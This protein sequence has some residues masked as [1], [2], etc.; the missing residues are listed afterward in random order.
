VRRIGLMKTVAIGDT[1]MLAGIARDVA[2]AFPEATLVLVTGEDNRAAAE[3]FGVA[4]ESLIVRP[5]APLA[6]ARAMRAADLDVLLD[7]GPWARFDAF[8]A[9]AAGARFSVGFRSAGQHRHYAY[10]VAIPH[11]GDRHEIDNFRALAHAIG[12]IADSDPHIKVPDALDRD[13]LPPAPYVVFHPWA[14]GF[15]R[16]LK[17]WPAE[18]WVALG[19]RLASRGWTIALSG[20]SG[21]REE[22][23][24][25]HRAFLDRG[26]SALDAAGRYTLAELA[27]FFVA[28]EAVVSVNTGVMHLA[29]QVGA[30]TVSLEG[31]TAAARWRPLGS[32]VVPVETRTP[33][34]GYLQLGWEYAGRRTDCML[35]IEVDD[36]ERAVDATRS[37]G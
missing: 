25:L 4:H 31:P 15:R 7:F 5:H 20:S 26:I 21:D 24:R 14:G 33:G 23:G 29:G 28:S 18:R 8:M 22:S 13:A 6:S 34:C 19:E 27:D 17:Q 3:L 9:A 37:L 30:R 16:E 10:D 1:L 12:V 2:A 11:R 35:G 32:R 36:V